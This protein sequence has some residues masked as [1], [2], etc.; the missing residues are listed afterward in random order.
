M[1]RL[2]VRPKEKL[3][4]LQQKDPKEC[5]RTLS[6][7]VNEQTNEQ[8]NEL[9]NEQ[10]NEQANEVSRRLS[11]TLPNWFKIVK[12]MAVEEI[13]ENIYFVN[14]SNYKL[15]DDSYDSYKVT[16][17]EICKNKILITPFVLDMFE[18][19]FD[20]MKS[21]SKRK[22]VDVTPYRFDL[23]SRGEIN[24]EILDSKILNART[25]LK[26]PTKEIIKTLTVLFIFARY[27]DELE[28]YV[29]GTKKYQPFYTHPDFQA[30]LQ[31][32]RNVLHKKYFNEFVQNCLYDNESYTDNLLKS[33]MELS[34]KSNDDF[35]DSDEI[36][37]Y[38]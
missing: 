12:N 2:F 29:H 30:K 31:N 25:S 15:Y 8:T 13:L 7:L 5:Q 11:R 22:G 10:T 18:Y 37:F 21:N 26:I 1:S 3:M 19:F 23:I 28:M 35:Q 17:D 4:T 32:Y 34:D 36:F 6:E 33:V 20:D 14:S 38:E 24:W 27:R 16:F 9:V